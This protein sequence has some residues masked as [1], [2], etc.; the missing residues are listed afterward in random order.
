MICEITQ[1][2][3]LLY[4]VINLTL[5]EI[6]NCCLKHVKKGN[7]ISHKFTYQKYKIQIP[8]RS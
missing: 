1:T 3:T 2:R 8:L 7:S 4:K 6:Y 5:Y